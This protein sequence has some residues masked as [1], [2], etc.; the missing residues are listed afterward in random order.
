MALNT[1]IL[2]PFR[3]GGVVGLSGAAFESL[4]AKVEAP[5]IEADKKK[6]LPI[7]IYH[8]TSDPVIGFERADES[9]KKLI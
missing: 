4:L 7:F 5:E 8:G 1:A 2:A 6:N 3:I 9:Y